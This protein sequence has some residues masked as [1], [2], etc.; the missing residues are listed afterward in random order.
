MD[1][2]SIEQLTVSIE[3][4]KRLRRLIADHWRLNSYRAVERDLGRGNAWLSRKLSGVK[5]MTLDDLDEILNG[6]ELPAESL[7]E[8]APKKRKRRKRKPA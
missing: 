1:T 8:P 2:V 7:L 5:P 3:L 4:R 6:L